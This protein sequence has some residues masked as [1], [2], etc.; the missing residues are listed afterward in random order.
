MQNPNHEDNWKPLE[1]NPDV[2]NPFAKTIG[3]IFSI[4]ILRTEY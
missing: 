3:M 4:I 2:M 1:S